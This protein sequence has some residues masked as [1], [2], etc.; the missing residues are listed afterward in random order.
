MTP[1]T[2]GRI[3]TGGRIH[4]AI[5]HTL[6]DGW[7]SRQIRHTIPADKINT[8]LLCQRCWTPARIRSAQAA[9]STATGPDAEAIRRLL[10]DQA[11]R[12]TPGPPADADQLTLDPAPTLTRVDATPPPRRTL[13]DLRAEFMATHKQPARRIA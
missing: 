11:G 9:L 10:A 6:G 12:L 1:T 5:H 2:I 4:L 13:A 7:T 8:K 3:A